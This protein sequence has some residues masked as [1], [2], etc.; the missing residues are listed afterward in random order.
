MVT[1]VY[2]CTCKDCKDFDKEFAKKQKISE[3]KLTQCPTCNNKTLEIVLQPSG[4]NLSGGGWT[5]SNIAGG[6]R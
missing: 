4:F 1:R 2:K 5:G 3:N 6:G